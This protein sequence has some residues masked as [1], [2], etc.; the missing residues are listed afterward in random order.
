MFQ[1]QAKRQ[2]LRLTV[3]AGMEVVMRGRRQQVSWL[4][5]GGSGASILRDSL[6][7]PSESAARDTEAFESAAAIT[8]A[9]TNAEVRVVG[10]V[11]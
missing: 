1:E 10:S 9:E 8:A 7:P 3:K 4:S 5:A 11:N 6:W 2:L